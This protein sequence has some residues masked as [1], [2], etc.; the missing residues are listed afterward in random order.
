ML[1]AELHKKAIT[2]EEGERKGF[3]QLVTN[4]R[5]F[6]DGDD[7]LGID[8]KRIRTIYPILV[9]LDHGFTAPYLNTLYNEEF[10]GASLRKEYRLL[11][12]RLFSLTIDDLENTLPHT[13]RHGFTDI[14]ESYFKANR[15][16]FGEFSRSS[17]P[18]LQ[19]EEAGKNVVRARFQQFGADLEH[20]FFPFAVNES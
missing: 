19:G 7:L 13:H 18:L 6:L 14:L 5:R 11:I 1:L 15:K 8:R 2:G 17:I 10:N 4:I 3:T 20:Q 16:M 9:F 12:T